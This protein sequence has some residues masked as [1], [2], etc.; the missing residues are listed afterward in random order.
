MKCPK[1]GAD[2]DKVVDSRSVR[3]GAAIR[4]RRECT[5]CGCRYTTFEETMPDDLTVVKTDGRRQPFERDKVDKSI[6]RA[7]GKRP[8]GDEQIRSMIDRVLAA[9][10]QGGEVAS[11]VI[12]SLVMNELHKTDEVAYVRFA[13]VYRKF[14]DVAQFVAEITEISKK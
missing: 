9:L 2:D 3:E 1:C 12:A 6:R 14:T 13:S 5:A 7:C 11:S 10:P 4:R 8:V